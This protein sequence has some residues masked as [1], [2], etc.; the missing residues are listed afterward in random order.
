V[1]EQLNRALVV[2]SVCMKKLILLALAL[3]AAELSAQIQPTTWEFASPFEG[4][5]RDDGSAFSLNGFGYYGCG[6]NEYYE[7]Q[8]DWWQY[9]PI[10]DQWKRIRD[11]P[12]LPRQYASVLEINGEVFLVGGSTTEGLTNEVY[13]FNASTLRWQQRADAPFFELAASASFSYGLHGYLIGGRNDSTKLKGFWKYD[14]SV[15]RWWS[16]PDPPFEAMDEMSA[17]CIGSKAYV[18]L[19]RNN[20]NEFSSDVYQ[21]EF[22]TE[23]WTKLDPFPGQARAYA[24]CQL[25]GREYAICAG[26]QNANDE[27]LNEVYLFKDNDGFMEIAPLPMPEIR[28]MQSF[29]LNDA[30]FFIGGL[31]PFF[32]RTN[33]VQKLV[34]ESQEVES[35]AL[36]V[37][38]NPSRG[39]I[40]ISVVDRFTTKIHQI[41]LHKIDQRLNLVFYR[42]IN[43]SNYSLDVSNLEAGVYSLR[44]AL[45]DGSTQ[46]SRIVVVK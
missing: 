43:L 14:P 21:Y 7:L 1:L 29:F 9:D 2:T 23:K 46:D 11:L 26:G 4:G 37:Y 33:V 17:F 5:K 13:R 20:E 10:S 19:G 40:E 42:S 8:K 15:D 16:L 41:N 28:G 6:I 32:T 24:D 36:L 35:N 25:I 45:S 39:F 3:L 31:T 18:L 27:L 12:G 44:V 38:P 30:V 34:F 22:I